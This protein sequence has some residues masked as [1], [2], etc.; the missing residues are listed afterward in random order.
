VQD[1]LLDEIVVSDKSNKYSNDKTYSFFP[2]SLY[3]TTRLAY[4]DQNKKWKIII[5]STFHSLPISHLV[6]C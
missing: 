3:L 4:D 5:K 1:I 6:A 2:F